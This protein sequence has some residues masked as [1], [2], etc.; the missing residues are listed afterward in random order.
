MPVNRPR[1]KQEALTQKIASPKKTFAR[2][3]LRALQ[4]RVEDLE[5]RL[6]QALALKKGVQRKSAEK[7]GNLGRIKGAQKKSAEKTNKPRSDPR[8]AAPLYLKRK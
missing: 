2:E 6:E 3:S 4:T 5:R 1:K 7:T 8:S